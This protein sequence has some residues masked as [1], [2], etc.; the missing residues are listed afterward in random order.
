VPTCGKTNQIRLS[1]VNM[2]VSPNT[3]G[4]PRFIAAII[5]TALGVVTLLAACGTTP[6]SMGTLTGTFKIV[7]GG[8]EYRTVPGAG[9]VIIR[10]G[11]RRLADHQVSSGST[12]KV[13]L[14]PGSYQVTATCVQSL[15]KTQLSTPKQIS[16]EAKMATRADIQC[17]LNP[18]VG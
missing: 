18:R 11:A 8:V 10:Q 12:F 1:C 7:T 16:I 13:T 5:V 9:H 4:R 14:A 17:L 2:G 6:T 15:E 3:I